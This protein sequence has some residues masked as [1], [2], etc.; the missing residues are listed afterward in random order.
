MEDSSNKNMKQVFEHLANI[1]MVD[2]SNILYTKIINKL[3]E[4]NTIS[5]Y[6]VKVAACFFVVFT[7]FEYYIIQSK[8]HSNSKDISVVMYKTNNIL[9]NE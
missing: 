1:K 9:Y 7:S 5:M 6:W 2:P 4:K 3:Q 8:T